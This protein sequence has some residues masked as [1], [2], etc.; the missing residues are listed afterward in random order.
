MLIEASAP[1]DGSTVS[2]AVALAMPVAAVIVTL[3]AD[4]ELEVVMTK[5]PVVAPLPIATVAGRETL[6]SELVREITVPPVC[7]GARRRMPPV[8]DEPPATVCDC[9]LTEP[10]PLTL[11]I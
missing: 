9:R 10:T 7:A 1:F 8:V 5:E 4:D 11:V 3:R 2:V 6:G